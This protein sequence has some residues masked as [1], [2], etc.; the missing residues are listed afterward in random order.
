M[1]YLYDY[2]FSF[3]F[4]NPRNFLPPSHHQVYLGPNNQTIGSRHADRVALHPTY[5]LGTPSQPSTQWTLKR[6]HFFSLDAY[7]DHRSM[8]KWDESTE[9][10]RKCLEEFGALGV[11]SGFEGR[12]ASEI[13]KSIF[14]VQ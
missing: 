1:K 12:E 3:G 14:Y 5:E 8:P 6:T 9:E 10:G 13:S 7:L 2:K 11:E 4:Y